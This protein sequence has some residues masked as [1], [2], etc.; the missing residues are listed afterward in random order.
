MGWISSEAEHEWDTH[1]IHTKLNDACRMNVMGWHMDE[2]TE[3]VHSL[4]N[5]NNNEKKRRIVSPYDDFDRFHRVKT[6]L[7]SAS[8]LVI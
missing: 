7:S 2:L 4:K 3:V 6:F 5:D 1:T 8:K